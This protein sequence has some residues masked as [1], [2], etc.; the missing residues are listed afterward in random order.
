M[1]RRHHAHYRL[2][3]QRKSLLGR[4]GIII[5]SKVPSNWSALLTPCAGAVFLYS[6]L[7]SLKHSD[8]H[9]VEPDPFHQHPGERHEVKIMKKN[10]YYL[11]SRL[12][13]GLK[14]KA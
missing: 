3:K 8:Y 5:Q 9:D 11:T 7:S 6:A 1:I 14:E 10:R 13:K 2:K 12:M 4:K